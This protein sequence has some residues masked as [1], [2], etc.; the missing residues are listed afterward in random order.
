VDFTIAALEQCMEPMFSSD[1]RVREIMGPLAGGFNRWQK[2]VS[3]RLDPGGAADSTLYSGVGEFDMSRIEPSKA[4][5]LKRL[6]ER[7][8]KSEQ[9]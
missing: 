2:E 1:P 5:R 9:E 3:K 6:I 7:Y 4:E 8:R